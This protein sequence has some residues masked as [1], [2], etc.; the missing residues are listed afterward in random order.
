MEDYNL[1]PK[2]IQKII[3]FW[4]NK[5]VLI[6]EPH[7]NADRIGRVVR[8][9][10]VATGSYGFVVECDDNSNLAKSFFVFNQKHLKII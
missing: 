9:D 10:R 5:K 4:L 3:R 1:L 6:L 8:F 2:E 7:P